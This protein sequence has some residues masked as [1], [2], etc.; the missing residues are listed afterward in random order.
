[1]NRKNYG[2]T[3][4]WSTKGE[5]SQGEDTEEDL[6]FDEAL[7][8]LKSLLK[9]LL[10]ECRRLNTMLPQIPSTKMAMEPSLQ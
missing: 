10:T 5:D 7:D 2:T 6:E 8:A 9:E 3:K 4:R 1:M